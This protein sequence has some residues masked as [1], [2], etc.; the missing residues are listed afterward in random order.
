M[1]EINFLK[2]NLETYPNIKVLISEKDIEKWSE[3]LSMY[4]NPI[5]DYVNISKFNLLTTL[6]RT[7]CCESSNQLLGHLE[8]SLIIFPDL[9]D[10]ETF[11]RN[12]KSLNGNAFISF[13]SELSFAKFLHEQGFN[14]NFNTKYKRIKN[15]KTVSRDIDIEAWSNNIKIYFEIYTPNEQIEI[16]RFINLS[17]FSD[18]FEQKIKNKEFEKF[19]SII[20]GHLN[21]KIILA[22]NYI[23]DDRFNIF[24]TAFKSDFFE[25]IGSVIHDKIDGILL[26][27]HDLATANALRIDKIIIKKSHK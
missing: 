24:L 3:K 20:N 21:G 22:I 5:T 15:G 13:L 6:I 26:Y 17:S 2:Q 4:E 11:K 27:Y 1:N 9:K 12:I 7:K 14:I 23:Y 18:K 16:N 10:S 8:N 25:K 19:D